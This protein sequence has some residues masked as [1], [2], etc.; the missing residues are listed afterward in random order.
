MH[1][2]WCRTP[3]NADRR[4]DLAGSGILLR[5]VDGYADAVRID[6]PDRHAERE[7]AGSEGE[8]V[9]ELRASRNHLSVSSSP[10]YEV[11]QPATQGDP[12]SRR[13]PTRSAWGARLTAKA[14][15]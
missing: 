12:M 13:S 8:C 9:I 6:S 10:P 1:H 3:V 4:E 7:R 2:V 5:K 15:E 11:E 14:P